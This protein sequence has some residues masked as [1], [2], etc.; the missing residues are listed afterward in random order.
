MTYERA[1]QVGTTRTSEHQGLK[2]IWL[3]FQKAKESMA[4]KDF[5]YFLCMYIYVFFFTYP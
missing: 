1:V 2:G 5:M 4:E 3:G